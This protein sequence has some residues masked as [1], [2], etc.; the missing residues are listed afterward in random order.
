MAPSMGFV[1]KK[2][3]Y[4]KREGEEDLLSNNAQPKGQIV[5]FQPKS[6]VDPKWSLGY[7]VTLIMIYLLVLIVAH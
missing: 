1:R 5:A 3:R 6:I 2:Q 4:P 7:D